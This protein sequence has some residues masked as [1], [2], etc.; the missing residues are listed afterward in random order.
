MEL[1]KFTDEGVARFRAYLREAAEGSTAGPPLELLT[2]AKTSR[3]VREGPRIEPMR[4]ANRLELARYLDR[5]FEN[6]GERPDILAN[7]VAL[8][9]WLSLCYFD[10]VCPANEQ[11]RRKPGRDYRHIPEPGYPS[12]HRHLLMGPYLVY[13]VYGWGDALSRLSLHSVLSKESQFH[14]EIC[15]RQSLVTNRGVMEAL[16]ILYYDE[17]HSRPKRGPIANKKAPGSL[18]RFID[19]IQQ[20]DVTFD[21][22]SMSGHE[23]VGLLPPEFSPWLDRQLKLHQQ[24]RERGRG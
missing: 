23:I 3:P 21:L 19:V 20:L 16:H 15:S 4:F 6:L 2:D 17:V 13:T 1:R 7:D 12:G 11:G 8:W 18:Y 24:E 9:S 5:T 10:Q 22:Y 14:H